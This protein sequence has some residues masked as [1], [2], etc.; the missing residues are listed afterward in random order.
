MVCTSDPFFEPPDPAQMCVLL[1]SPGVMS[2]LRHVDYFRVALLV[3][4]VN[5]LGKES[6]PLRLPRGVCPVALH[7]RANIA[8]V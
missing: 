6:Y 3:L 1:V 4:T 5:S 2:G 8:N 7:C